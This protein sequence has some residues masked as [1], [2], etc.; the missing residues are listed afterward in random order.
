MS[1]QVKESS[2][3]NFLRR[4]ILMFSELFQFARLE[5]VQVVHDYVENQVSV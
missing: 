2:A 1:K 5:L 3:V 4:S